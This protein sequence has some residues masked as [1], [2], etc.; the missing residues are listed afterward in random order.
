MVI[1]L[2]GRSVRSNTD[3][4]I[5]HILRTTMC[6]ITLMAEVF[7]SFTDGVSLQLASKYV[8]PTKLSG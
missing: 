7:R 3:G 8:C 1:A 5:L 2:D 4:D 6:T